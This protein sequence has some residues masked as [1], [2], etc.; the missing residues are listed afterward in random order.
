MQ[1]IIS[2]YVICSTPVS[3][4]RWSE[5]CKTTPGIDVM[6]E[7]ISSGVYQNMK[8][9]FINV[10]LCTFVIHTGGFIKVFSVNYSMDFVPQVFLF[11]V[12]FLL[13]C[14]YMCVCVFLGAHVFTHIFSLPVQNLGFLSE[15]KLICVSESGLFHWKWWSPVIACVL[16]QRSILFYFF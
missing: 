13:V 3:K 8:V 15:I 1:L 9:I 6:T 10:N 4:P 5:S 2:K 7:I 14:V 16:I 11:Q 12:A